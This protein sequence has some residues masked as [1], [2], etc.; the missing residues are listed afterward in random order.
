MK[1]RKKMKNTGFT[2]VELLVVIA[3]IGILIALLLPAVQAAREAARRMQCTNNLKQ[4]ALGCQNYLDTH[5]KFPAARA[6]FYNYTRAASA[7]GTTFIILPFVEQQAIYDQALQNMK[8][9]GGSGA[10]PDYAYPATVINT[11]SCPSDSNAGVKG[12]DGW[13]SSPRGEDGRIRVSY[14]TC[15]GDSF[16][17]ME[18]AD[19]L[20]NDPSAYPSY[21]SASER[22]GFA[23]FQFK[24]TEGITDGT[25][26]TIAWGETVTSDGTQDPHIKSGVATGF[27]NNNSYL[28]LC[29]AT[30]SGGSQQGFINGSSSVT[31][32]VAV[33][34]KGARMGDGRYQIAGF[35]TIFPPNSISCQ[36][37]DGLEMRMLRTPS[38]NHAGGIN[39]S[40]FDGSCR[41]ISET[42][43]AGTYTTPHALPYFG[44]SIYGVWGAM[45]STCGGETVTL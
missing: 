2:L 19:W 39:V 31:S 12:D 4:L 9:Y 43:D 11:F 27:S 41:F 17:L 45:G 29:Y 35:S 15:R 44:K 40:L 28:S 3:I 5:S 1:L 25:S 34:H 10:Y 6:Q 37:S 30:M 32:S 22:A 16:K 21:K 33:S 24:G 26:N 42:I 7:W 36:H 8:K 38:S 23:P 18:W 20:P 14:L 13:G